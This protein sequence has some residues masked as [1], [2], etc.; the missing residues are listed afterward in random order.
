M[1]DEFHEI[2]RLSEYNFLVVMH[3][4]KQR[5]LSSTQ[6]KS[7]YK[8][9]HVQTTTEQVVGKQRVSWRS[10]QNQQAEKKTLHTKP[11]FT[12]D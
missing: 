5:S 4:L 2:Q 7:D 11:L 12:T 8:P 1:P 10:V 3:D 9:K 6:F